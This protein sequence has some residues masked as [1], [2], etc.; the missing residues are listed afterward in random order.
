MDIEKLSVSFVIRARNVENDLPR[1]IDSILSQNNPTNNKLEIIVVDNESTDNTL[2]IAH[3]YDAKVI[4]ITQDQFTWGKALNIGIEQACGDIVILISADV[5]AENNMW[6]SE[7]LSPFSNRKIAAVYAKQIPRSDAP[8]DERIRLSHTFPDQSINFDRVSTKIIA[9]NACAAIRKTVWDNVHYDEKIEGGEEIVWTKE[10]QENG[11]TYIYNSN[12]IVYHSHREPASRFAYRLWELHRKDVRL[13]RIKP[14]VFYV[15][16][17]MAAIVKRRL[18]N[19]IKYKNPLRVK[20]AGLFSLLPE[21]LFFTL[22]SALEG[23]GIKEK[24]V[25]RWMW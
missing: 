13:G 9:S 4:T 20:A 14:G 21:V 18:I 1:C 25:R 10:I 11:Y 23:V 2:I 15:L 22:I 6:L 7:M 24:T 12:A 5:N 3:S 17:A 19:I 8:I 16:Y